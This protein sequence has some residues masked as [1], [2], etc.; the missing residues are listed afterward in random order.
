[1][2]AR[3]S[4]ASPGWG[5]AMRIASSTRCPRWRLSAS[6]IRVRRCRSISFCTK[7]LG[8]DKQGEP[9]GD[10]QR[11][12]ERQPGALLR[13]ERVDDGA[14]RWPA[15]WLSAASSL[16]SATTVFHTAANG[17]SG[18]AVN[19]DNPLVHR[20]RADKETMTAVHIVIHRCGQGQRLASLSLGVSLLGGVL[21]APCRRG[22]S[23]TDQAPS[24]LVV[25]GLSGAA[26][27][28]NGMAEANRFRVKEP[29]VPQH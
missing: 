6:T 17:A 14:G 12:D 3:G 24:L 26:P 9:F 4:S 11:F 22:E 29:T 18:S 23:G 25:C 8:T 20:S 13:G 21:S 5:G 15:R 16:S 2:P 7:L 27:R 1:M 10:R 28:G 19:D